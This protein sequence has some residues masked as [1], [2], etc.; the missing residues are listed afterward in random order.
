MIDEWLS[1]LAP[2]C[3]FAL[4]LPPLFFRPLTRQNRPQGAIPLTLRTTVIEQALDH[5]YLRA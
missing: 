5:Q 1:V 3:C 2:L 4:L